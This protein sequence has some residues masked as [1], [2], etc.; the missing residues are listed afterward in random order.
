MHD[1]PRLCETCA[2]GYQHCNGL[3]V[4]CQCHCGMK[5]PPQLDVYRASGTW[6]KPPGAKTICAVVQASGDGMAVMQVWIASEVPDQADIVIGAGT[7]QEGWSDPWGSGGVEALP[8]MPGPPGAGGFAVII[9][10]F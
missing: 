5:R 3:A 8:V 6:R 7:G 10:E 9:T 2:Q 1:T 4:R